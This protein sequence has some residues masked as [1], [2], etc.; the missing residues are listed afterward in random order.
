MRWRNEARAALWTKVWKW[1]APDTL[2]N[3]FNTETRLPVY[4]SLFGNATRLRYDLRSPSKA[5]SNF[6]RVE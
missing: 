3:C 1:Y 2:T 5:Q 6:P 4:R